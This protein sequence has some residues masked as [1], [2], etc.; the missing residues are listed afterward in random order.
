[1]TLNEITAKELAE[2]EYNFPYKLKKI[3]KKYYIADVKTGKKKYYVG[4]K[5]MDELK[6]LVERFIRTNSW[7][8]KFDKKNRRKII[9]RYVKKLKESINEK[10][11]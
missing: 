2:K 1:M 7:F 11:S 10:N 4:I 5:E 9:N 6:D 3:G 8:N